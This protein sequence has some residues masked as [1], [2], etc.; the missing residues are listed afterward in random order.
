[1]ATR[2]HCHPCMAG[3]PKSHPSY[4]GSGC[5]HPVPPSAIGGVLMGWMVT[6]Q[7]RGP[8]SLQLACD[9]PPPPPLGPLLAATLPSCRAS[10]H[11]WPFPWAL[12]RL[13]GGGDETRWP[14][15]ALLRDPHWG[16]TDPFTDSSSRVGQESGELVLPKSLPPSLPQGHPSLAPLPPSLPHWGRCSAVPPRTALTPSPSHPNG[17]SESHSLETPVSTFPAGCKGGSQLEE[18]PPP[19]LW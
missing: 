1:M 12:R 8:V 19:D 6:W 16:A 7:W 3:S 14:S 18:G 17:T 9:C 15:L 10:G 5:R 11:S 13:G 4:P 2:W